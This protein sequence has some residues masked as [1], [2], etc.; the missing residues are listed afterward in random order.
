M[1]SNASRGLA[2]GLHKATVLSGHNALTG[3]SCFA[4][5]EIAQFS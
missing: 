3:H 4:N 2:P 5:R 1:A